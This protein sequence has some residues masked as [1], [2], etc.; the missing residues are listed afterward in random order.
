MDIS[1]VQFI[2]GGLIVGAFGSL[3][4]WIWILKHNEMHGLAEDIVSA[5]NEVT[6][7]INTVKKDLTTRMDKLEKNFNETLVRQD[8]ISR[9][10]TGKLHDRLDEHVQELH[11]KNPGS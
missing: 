7:A 4:G 2:V 1:W 5:K 8:S 6:A 11:V 9:A 10:Q 3:T